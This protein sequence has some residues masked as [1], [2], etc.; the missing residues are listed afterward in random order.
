MTPGTPVRSIVLWFP[1]WPVTALEREAGAAAAAEDAVGPRPGTRTD[2][3]QEKFEAKPPVA[4]VE[5]NLV[6]A[7]SAAAA[8]PASRSR[9]V[10]GQSGNQSTMLRTG[11]PGVM[12]PHRSDLSREGLRRLGRGQHLDAPHAFGHGGDVPRSIRKHHARPP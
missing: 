1:D 5:R 8:V 7:C 4:V 12:S 6:V 2:A 9:A 10:T 11:V 3:A